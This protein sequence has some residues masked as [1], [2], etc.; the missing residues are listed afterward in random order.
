MTARGFFAA[1]FLVAA[2]SFS[3][4]PSGPPFTIWDTLTSAC[5]KKFGPLDL[6]DTPLRAFVDLST[7]ETV[8]VT[9]DSTSRLSRGPGPLNTTRDCAIVWNSTKSPMP[10]TYATND[11][12]LDATW[13]FGNGTVVAL[14]HDEYPGMN[15]PGQ[16]NVTPFVWPACWMVSL[17]LAVSQ[18][19][20]RTWAHSAPP[21]ANLVAAVPY[22]YTPTATIF[23]WGDTG[24]IVAHPTDGFFYAAM[25][26]RMAVGLQSNG[27]CVM[28]TRTLLDPRSWRAWGGEAFD[29]ALVSAY[30]MPP[31]EEGAHVCTVLTPFM[32]SP[33]TVLGTTYSVFLS[34]FVAT[35]SCWPDAQPVADDPNFY[36]TTSTDFVH[37]EPARVLFTPPKPPHTQFFLY[38]ALLDPD[39][40]LRGDHNFNT[41][42]ETA[43]LSYVRVTDNAFTQGRQMLGVHINFSVSSS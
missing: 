41:I 32:P 10:S 3:A 23:G 24:G 16:C 36:W 5:E 18:D 6:P 27:T 25:N 29:V 31:G 21:P 22:K 38:P 42:G 12:F 13:S 33:C 9:V 30:K 43:V 37:W 28:R 35:I 40:P 1:P 15:I 17:S 7:Q 39:A 14:L 20:G 8:L 11:G 34:A 19:W 2:F 4:S 26:N